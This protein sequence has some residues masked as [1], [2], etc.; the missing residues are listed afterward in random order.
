MPWLWIPPPQAQPVPALLGESLLTPEA[1]ELWAAQPTGPH[2]QS[3]LLAVLHFQNHFQPGH[4]SSVC[5][6]VSHTEGYLSAWPNV[7]SQKC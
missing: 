5:E 4:Q 7:G 2:L 1:P 3:P 6:G